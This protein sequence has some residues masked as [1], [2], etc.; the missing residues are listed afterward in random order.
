MGQMFERHFKAL[1]KTVLISDIESQ[2]SEKKLVL[3]CELIILSVPIEVTPTVVK[4][5]KPWL[6]KDQLI[7]DF[8]SVKNKAIPAMM[9]TDA[10]IIS[11]HPMFGGMQDMSGQNII[12]LPVREGK[13]LAKYKRLYQDLKLNITIMEDWKKH[14]VSMSF[15]QGLM[16]FLHIVFTQ[17]LKAK[18]VDLGAILS[19]CSP[20]YQAN[21]AFVCRIFQR[22]PLLYTHILMDNPENVSVLKKFIDEAQKSLKLIQKKD[23]KKLQRHFLEYRDYLGEYGEIFS[24]QSDY[25]VEKLRVQNLSSLIHE[26]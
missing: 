7:S 23:E 14:D 19:M 13:F 11:S 8:T 1:G 2:Q 20:I 3:N 5:I 9:K 10:S 24:A 21:F 16:H 22:N 6:K 26:K 25:L 12:L 4:R 18:Q 15:I 17:T